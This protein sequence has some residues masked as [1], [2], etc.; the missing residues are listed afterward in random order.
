MRD[1][2]Q[3][4]TDHPVAVHHRGGHTSF[5]NSKGATRDEDLCGWPDLRDPRGLDNHRLMREHALAVHRHDRD[6][7]KRGGRSSVDL[8]VR[9]SM[10]LLAQPRIGA[11]VSRIQTRTPPSSLT[12]P[13]TVTHQ[14]TIVSP[15]PLCPPNVRDEPR[16]S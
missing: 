15:L 8:E 1:L 9:S 5:Y 2:D 13:T 7:H 10:G 16:R 4:S 6:I 12:Q 14:T 3:V 11:S